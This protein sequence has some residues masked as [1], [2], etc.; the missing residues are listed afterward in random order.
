MIDNSSTS[1]AALLSSPVRPA[2]K[3]ICPDKSIK[4]LSLE[5]VAARRINHNKAYEER[6]RKASSAKLNL[7]KL[8]AAANQFAK[9]L[10]DGMTAV[11]CV[12]TAKTTYGALC[13]VT[14]PGDTFGL[15]GLWH[16]SDM[17]GGTSEL[18]AIAV[19]CEAPIELSIIEARVE[20]SGSSPMVT[21]S[22]IVT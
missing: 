6:N 22:F 10:R 4:R 20:N 3:P 8:N 14:T 19:D 9:K 7:A 16:V 17:P 15:T 13:R 12:C 18:A 5:E 21:L 11:S 2:I 1:I